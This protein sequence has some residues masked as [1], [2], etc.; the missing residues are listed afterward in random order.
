MP[1]SLITAIASGLTRPGR[2]PALLTS[3]RSAASWASNPSAIWLRAELPV[4][5]IKTRF[6]MS[7]SIKSP[8]VIIHFRPENAEQL[9]LSLQPEARAQATGK[10]RSRQGHREAETE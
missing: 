3:K 7:F 8:S 6:F 10:E 4:Q 2:V 1:S 9:T 5:R